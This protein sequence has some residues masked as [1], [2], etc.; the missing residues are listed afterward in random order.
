M[1]IPNVSTPLARIDLTKLD[2]NGII[3][4]MRALIKS[5]DK[6]DNKLTSFFEGDVAIMMIELFSQIAHL[7]NL[8][9]D[10]LANELSWVN[11][12]QEQTIL[13]FLPLIDYQL[14]SVIG[15]TTNVIATVLNEPGNVID[16]QLTIP[17]RTRLAATNLNGNEST[18][19]ILSDRNDYTTAVLLRPGVQNYSIQ[20]YAG[21][22]EFVDLTVTKAENFVFK[23]NRENIIND[24]IQIFLK[25]DNNFTLLPQVS[26]FIQPLDDLPQYIVRFNF[27]GEPTVSFGNRFFGGKFDGIDSDLPQTYKEIR[28]YFRSLIDENGEVTNYSP[29][30]VNDQ[31]DFFVPTLG[32]TVSLQFFNELTGSGGENI[33]SISEVKQIAPLTIRT[34]NKAVTNED[35]EIY[36]SLNPIVKDVRVITPLEE[37]DLNIPIF[38]SHIYVAPIRNATDFIP[39]TSPILSNQLPDI[40]TNETE[41]EYNFRMLEALTEFYNPTGLETKASLSSIST[42]DTFV[43]TTDFNDKMRIV[44]DTDDVIS[45]YIDVILPEGIAVTKDEVV[46]TINSYFTFDIASLND[47]EKI[48]LT[49]N[50]YGDGSFLQLIGSDISIEDDI[51]S[52]TYDT[53]GFVLNQNSIGNAHTDEAESLLLEVENKKI[54]CVDSLVKQIVITPFQIKADVFYNRNFNPADVEQNIVDALFDTH[55]YTS[56]PL[57][58]TVRR[59][60]VIKTILDIDGVDY[61]ELTDFSNDI[62]ALANEI[63]FLLD[64]FI[65]NNFPTEFPNLKNRYEV[66]LNMIRSS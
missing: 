3:E 44:A 59:T 51:I 11:A 64:P 36:L 65:I 7:N 56:A 45:G 57:G 47:N 24:S 9:M 40:E 16:T 19:E 29:G 43:I 17:A 49:S 23:I 33:L 39:A 53:L 31:L 34:A 63:L 2:Y 35:Y 27:A 32:R 61:V 62:P 25:E 55:S 18:L 10:F 6:Y 37:P 50:V 20:C 12:R 46:D 42:D 13:N 52:E 54:A 14:Q 22:T 5:N 15:S 30:A 66:Q 4:Q 58:R 1:A 8:R 60:Q 28:I 48:T 38:Y 26:S 21:V 41:D